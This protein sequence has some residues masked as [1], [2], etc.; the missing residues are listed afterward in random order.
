MAFSTQREVDRLT[1]Q[2]GATDAFVADSIV[3]GLY[4]RI[5]GNRRTWVVR[6]DVSGKRRKMLIGEVGAISLTDARKEASRILGQIR[7]GADPLAER[8]V[9]A[10]TPRKLTVGDL[11]ERYLR[12]HAKPSQRPRT[13]LETARAL[14]VHL[15][16]LHAMEADALARRNLADRFLEIREKSG[17][18]AA[19]R[20]R[21]QVSAM[22]SWAMG[23]GLAG[24]NPVIG[25]NKSPGEKPRERVLSEDEIR[26][27][28]KATTS[29]ADYA[30]IIR[31]LLLT[32]QRRD[33]VAGMKWSE[34]SADGR[35]WTIPAE[36][37]KNKR[38]HDVPLSTQAQEILASVQRRDGIDTIFGRGEN[39][40]SGY[41]RSKD[42]LDRR[43]AVMRAEARM[44]RP[45]Q[46]DEGPDQNDWLPDWRLHDLRRTTAT[47]MAE[48]GLAAPHVI[49][50][51]L[52]HQG[53]HKA[54][55]AAVY[56]RATYSNEKKLALQAWADHV[57]QIVTRTISS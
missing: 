9:K 48:H 55:I 32:T 52:N 34:I 28:W 8:E 19:N 26:W 41:S 57:D 11:A 35:S 38:Q 42:A 33:E 37:A 24:E 1:V 36:R 54:G 53:G 46:A 4:V 2:D 51:V 17:P 43:I 13:Y 40:Y 49:E 22:Y 7:N 44:G 56:N 6:Y 47:L 23:E 12:V 18:V 45:L 39:G 31:L 30:R 10:K 20:V 25:T 3:R 15:A 50:M 29:T 16:P 14:Q 5:Q 21:A 27:I